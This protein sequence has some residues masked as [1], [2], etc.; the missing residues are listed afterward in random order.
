M[1]ASDLKESLAEKSSNIE[2]E[3]TVGIKKRTIIW[4]LAFSGFAVNFVITNNV[5]FAIINMVDSNFQSSNE[6]N[7][8]LQL[9]QEMNNETNVDEH[10]VDIAQFISLE[11]R[12]L[13]FLNVS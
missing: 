1:G 4:F 8:D 3:G 2:S 11:R 9:I 12:L 10:P 6:S 7:Q 5:P 13:D